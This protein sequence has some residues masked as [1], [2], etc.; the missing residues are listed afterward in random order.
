MQQI[1]QYIHKKGGARLWYI[2][3]KNKSYCG[4][5]KM[6]SFREKYKY[7]VVDI[8]GEIYGWYQT[9]AIAIEVRDELREMYHTKDIYYREAR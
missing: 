1:E 3:K 4:G 6:D 8:Y 2:R 5:G 7:V 9:E